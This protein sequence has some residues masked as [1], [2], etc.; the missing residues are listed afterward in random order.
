MMV[1]EMVGMKGDWKVDH[2]ADWM[3]VR[4]VGSSVRWRAE[5][6]AASMVC[7]TVEQTA[8]RSAC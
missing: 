6:M 4:T 3:V 8:V 1:A 5:R 2:W 7:S